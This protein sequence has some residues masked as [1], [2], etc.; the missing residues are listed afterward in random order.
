M[1]SSSSAVIPDTKYANN[2]G[3]KAATTTGYSAKELNTKLVWRKSEA[4]G[5]QKKNYKLNVL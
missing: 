1:K 2:S 4:T 5:N 3:E